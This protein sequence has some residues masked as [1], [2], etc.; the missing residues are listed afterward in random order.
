MCKK[1]FLTAV[2]TLLGLLQTSHPSWAVGVDKSPSQTQKNQASKSKKDYENNFSVSL[3]KAFFVLGVYYY[4]CGEPPPPAKQ[5]FERVGVGS[6]MN[7][8][9]QVGTEVHAII[10][11]L[12]GL[13]NIGLYGP[14]TGTSI[15]FPSEGVTMK[16]IGGGLS[17]RCDW[18]KPYEMQ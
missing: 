13:G 17:P 9:A 6:T 12:G 14:Q 1:L 8:C 18:S 16:C 11:G 10:D 4:K 5:T 3:N 2:L 15:T 7:R